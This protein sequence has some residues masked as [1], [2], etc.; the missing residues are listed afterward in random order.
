MTITSQRVN[1]VLTPILKLV[2]AVV[3]LLLLQVLVS[4]LPMM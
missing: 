1:L 2:I 3:G 4:A